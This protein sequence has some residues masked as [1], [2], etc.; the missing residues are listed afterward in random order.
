[1]DQRARTISLLEAVNR[2]DVRVVQRCEEV[3][4]APKSREPTRVSL[5]NSS[6]NTLTATSR[7]R[8]VSLAR[9][10]SPMPPAPSGSRIS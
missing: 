10:T 2:C 5:T 7:L 9:Y 6:G 4:L 3:R 8:E 1:M